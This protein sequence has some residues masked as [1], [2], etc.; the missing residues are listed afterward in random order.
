[1]EFRLV[2]ITLFRSVLFLCGCDSQRIFEQNTDIE[3]RQWPKDDI[4]QFEFE[5]TDTDQSYDIYYNIRNSVAFPF[6]N[7]FLTYSLQDAAG[8]ELQSA[9]QNMN[10]FDEKTGKPL[11]N[12]MG[13]IFDLQVL[14]VE[15][16]SFDHPGKYTFTIQQ[17]MRRDTLNEIL[18]I[19]IRVERNNNE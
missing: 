10:L 18:S 6:H 11:G 19:G 4:K 8:N 7:L 13:D 9:L 14:S 15:N 16:Y 1:M 5:I 3:N 2:F 12:G 17:F